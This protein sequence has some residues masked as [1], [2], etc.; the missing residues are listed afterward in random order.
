[1]Q[2]KLKFFMVDLSR[3]GLYVRFGP[4]AELTPEN[5]IKRAAFGFVIKPAVHM[6]FSERYGGWRGRVIGRL[7]VRTYQRRE[8]LAVPPGEPK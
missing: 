2:I 8:I 5:R 3:F 7:Y 4:Y 6:W 1:M